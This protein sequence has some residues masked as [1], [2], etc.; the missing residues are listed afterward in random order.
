MKRLPFKAGDI[1]LIRNGAS[2]H[3]A[4]VAAIGEFMTAFQDQEAQKA[5][6]IANEEIKD[7]VKLIEEDEEEEEE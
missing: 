6:T 2:Y 4:R 3:R 1:V 7:N 5:L